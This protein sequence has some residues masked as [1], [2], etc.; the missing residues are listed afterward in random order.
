MTQPELT[1]PG[2]PEQTELLEVS[3]LAVVYRRRH[4]LLG[5][6][7]DQLRAVDGVSLRVRE[8]EA[9]GLVGESGSGKSTVAQAITRLVPID[10]GSITLDGRPLGR[11]SG[12]ALRDIRRDLQMVFQDPY[13]SLDPSM[14]IRAALREPLRVLGLQDGVDVNAVLVSA[15]EAVG[16]P[17][18]SLEKFPHEFSGGQR[19]RIAI[20]RALVPEPRMLILDEA[21]SALDVSTQAQVLGLLQDLRRERGLAYLFIGHD[22]AV[23]RRMSDRIAVMYLGR[24]VEEGPAERVVTSPAHPYTAALLAAVPDGRRDSGRERRKLIRRGAIPDPWNR[25]SG[26]SFATRCPFA[27]DICHEQDPPSTRLLAGGE[28]SCH[29]QTTGPTLAGDVLGDLTA[30]H[31]NEGAENAS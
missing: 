25:P 4:G 11:A 14:T 10:S 20:A 15:L 19:Q 28:V 3:D 18:S 22:L 1:F 8:G 5:R 9:L 13:S 27:M 23:V 30:E 2:A 26:C 16:L 21:V 29:L 6:S 31:V 12:K 24:V 7:Q 17:A